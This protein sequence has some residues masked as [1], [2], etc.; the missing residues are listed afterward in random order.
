M[1]QDSVYEAVVQKVVEG[2]HGA[3]AIALVEKPKRLSVTFSLRRRVWPEDR[4]PRPGEKVVLSHLTEKRAGWRAN[5]ARFKT[6][7]DLPTI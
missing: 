5:K 6:P 1:S 7:S 3:Y 2:R 4:R